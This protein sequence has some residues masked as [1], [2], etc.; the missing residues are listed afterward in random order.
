[1]SDGRV[2]ELGG[3]NRFSVKVDDLESMVESLRAPGTR[4]GNDMV[5][6]TG[7]KQI[8]GEDPTENLSDPTDARRGAAQQ[9]FQSLATRRSPSQGSAP[10]QRLGTVSSIG[11]CTVPVMMTGANRHQ[12]MELTVGQFQWSLRQRLVV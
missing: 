8:L 4:L 2:P 9:E 6:G 3:R 7:G 5:T 10:R 11:R 1:M 12:P